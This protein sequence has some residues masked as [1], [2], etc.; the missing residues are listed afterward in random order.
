VRSAAVA[1]AVAAA[2]VAAGCGGESDEQRLDRWQRQ[3]DGA[4]RQAQA[5]IADR[6][7]P[8]NVRDFDRVVGTALN[9]A[10]AAIDAITRQPLPQGSEARVRPFVDALKTLKPRLHRLIE[11]RDYTTT[12]QREAA[13][14]KVKQRLEA[15]GRHARR[16][17]LRAC[18]PDDLATE[19][20][21]ALLRPM[22]VEGVKRA[23]R[24]RVAALRRAQRLP[25]GS[26][27]AQWR[28]LRAREDD[29]STVVRRF[30]ELYPPSALAQPL[31]DC[32]SAIDRMQQLVFDLAT[33]ALQGELGYAQARLHL[34]ARR[35]DRACVEL[36]EAVS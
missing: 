13:L 4:C 26:R 5:R 21:D 28:Y 3:V 6:G 2:V 12:H 22:F 23:E 29:L 33:D 1:V 17:G 20:T 32:A 36:H 10:R 14:Y 27:L 9:D 11:A 7:R 8:P 34:L 25:D 19:V 30:Y 16:A 18:A 31:E 24:Q 35:Q 15:L